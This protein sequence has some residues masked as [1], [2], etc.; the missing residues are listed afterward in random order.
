[1]RS[2][3]AALREKGV[4][5]LNPYD[6]HALATTLAPDADSTSIRI[7]SN[8]ITST[9]TSTSTSSST[10]INNNSTTT[11]TSNSTTINNNSNKNSTK[12]AGSSNTNNKHGYSIYINNY[13]EMSMREALRCDL[14]N[15][16]H[17]TQRNATE[18]SR[19]EQR[20][21][22]I[23]TSNQSLLTSYG[24]VRKHAGVLAVL[25]EVV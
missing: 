9:S 7:T 5:L 13:K 17:M 25:R 8:T 22:N 19:E 11:S 10:N 4:D 1:M 12:D 14:R 20:Q 16:S 15:G 23:S 24:G 3:I 6:D 2:V 18:S 21:H